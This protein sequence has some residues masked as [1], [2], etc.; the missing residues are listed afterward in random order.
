MASESFLYDMVISVLDALSHNIEFHLAM[1][2]SVSLALLC[3]FGSCKHL[4]GYR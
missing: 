3:H 4:K 1:V 2:R